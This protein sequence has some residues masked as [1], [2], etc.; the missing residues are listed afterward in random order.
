MAK[1]KIQFHIRLYRIWAVW[2]SG[3]IE[4]RRSFA[5]AGSAK[6]RV[7]AL[8]A[9]KGRAGGSRLL[10]ATAVFEQL[11][12]ISKDASVRQYQVNNVW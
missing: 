6:A 8:R 7:F 11:G 5:V 12:F 10:I 3:A 2:G 4:K 9:R 1:D